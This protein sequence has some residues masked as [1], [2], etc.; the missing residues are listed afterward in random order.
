MFRE[1]TTEVLFGS[2]FK[3][4]ELSMVKDVVT[5]Q[6][7]RDRLHRFTAFNIISI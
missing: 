5:I 7:T 2:R 3:S 6:I 4:P 1:I